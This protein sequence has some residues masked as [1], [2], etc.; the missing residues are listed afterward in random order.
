MM[1]LLL[2][3]LLLEIEVSTNQRIEPV[4]YQVQIIQILSIQLIIHFHK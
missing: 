3:T 2:I 4:I 1:L